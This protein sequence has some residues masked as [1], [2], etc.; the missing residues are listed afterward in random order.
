MKENKTRL[1]PHQMDKSEKFESWFYEDE[2][3]IEIYSVRY[4]DRK[5]GKI[6]KRKLL[7]VLSRIYNVD[8]KKY[9]KS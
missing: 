5:V 2:K 1:A 9:I 8:F 7:G 6:S 4:P 3:G